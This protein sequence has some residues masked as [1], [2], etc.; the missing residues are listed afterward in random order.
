MAESF[1]ALCRS[2]KRF[3]AALAGLG[4]S[5]MLLDADLGLANV[6]VLLGMKA[7]LNLDPARPVCFVL[8]QRSWTDLFVL[9]RICRD[10][11]LPRPHRVVGLLKAAEKAALKS[12]EP[13][14]R[15]LLDRIR[16]L[17]RQACHPAD[18]EHFF[19]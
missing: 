13:R 19:R 1:S 10:L 8:P 5:T 3:G 9:D 18:F 12:S 17:Q 4:R 7:R 2:Q 14:H 16:D 11:G 6:D 15:D